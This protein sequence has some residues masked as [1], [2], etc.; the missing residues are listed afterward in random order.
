MKVRSN[1]SRA[2][3]RRMTALGRQKI[4]KARSWMLTK[5]EREGASHKRNWGT[6]TLQAQELRA[7]AAATQAVEDS[8]PDSAEELYQ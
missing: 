4:R 1:F 8:G 7:R 3:R 2:T 5:G 6:S